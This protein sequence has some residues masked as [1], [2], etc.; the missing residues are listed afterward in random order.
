MSGVESRL[1]DL[2]EA[3]V[4]EPPHRVTIAAVR[5]RVIRRRVLEAATVVA[6][7]VVVAGIAVAAAARAPGAGRA[8]G[9]VSHAGAPRYYVQQSFPAARQPPAVVRATVSG[10]VTATP[11]CPWPKANIAPQGF[12]SAGHQAFFMICER[13]ARQGKVF[14]VTGTRIY[15]LQL[16]GSGRVSGYSPVPGGALGP[17]RPEGITAT[18]DG[19]E[20]AVIAGPATLGRLPS[21]PADI[22]VINTQTGARAVWHGGAAVFSAGSLTFTTDGSALEFIGIKRCALVRISLACQ[23]LRAVGHATTGGQ[24][25]NSRLLLPLSALKLQP[26]DQV[27]DVVLSPDGLTLTAAVIPNPKGPGRPSSILV[28]EYSAATGRQLR[29]LYQMHAGNGFF[30]RFL[31]SDPTGRYLIF[32]AGPA[33]GT[34]NGWIDH[35]RL[36]RLK[37]ADG[38]NVLYET[39]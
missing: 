24:L 31:S 18:L 35:G 36:I 11:T 23:Q 5:R 10:R 14:V 6:A 17:H 34:V 7:A 39:W 13:I 30:Y 21:A 37:P 4:G 38:S 1:R 15:R 3:A 27:N 8:S 16:T 20:V 26:G 2:L 29:I 19:S 12:A 32:N 22:V 33:S 28:T 9:P 25:D